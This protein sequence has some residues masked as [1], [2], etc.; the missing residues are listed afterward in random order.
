MA[1]N[2]ISDEEREFLDDFVR[3]V[4]GPAGRR[5][6]D[7]RRIMDG[8]SWIE[9]TGA[10]LARSAGGIRQVVKRLMP[11]PAL[12]AGRTLGVDTRRS[13]RERYCPRHAA[14]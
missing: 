10:P 6:R 2:L 1:R 11:V 12:D 4:R 14:E 8:I 9:R 5:A 7:H 13:Q 3:A